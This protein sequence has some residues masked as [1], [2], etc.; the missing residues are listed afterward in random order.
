VERALMAYVIA[1]GCIDVKDGACVKC[2]PVDCI[3]EGGRTLY[4]HPDECISCGICVS[5][6][7]TEAIHDEMELPPGEAVFAAVNRE[8]FATYVSGVGSPGGADYIGPLACDHPVVAGYP[9]RSEP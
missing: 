6:C 4:I 9:V 1:S 3:Y 8:F 7:P 5:V 2:C